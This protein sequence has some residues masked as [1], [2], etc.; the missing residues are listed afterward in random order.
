M[1]REGGSVTEDR[2]PSG[3]SRSRGDDMRFG[4][5]AN[6]RADEAPSLCG[7]RSPYDLIASAGFDTTDVSWDSPLAAATGAT[8]DGA[9][10][11][12]QARPVSSSGLERVCYHSD[13]LTPDIAAAENAAMQERRMRSACDLACS[14][15]LVHSLWVNWEPFDFSSARECKRYLDFD[16]STLL[17]VSSRCSARRL[18]LVIEN[19]PS[20]PLQYYVDLFGEIPPESAGMCLDVGHA[21][22]Q[23]PGYDTPLAAWIQALGDRIEHLHLHGNDGM[24]D[25]HLPVLAPGGTVDWKACFQALKAVSYRG[26]IHEELPPW[27]GAEL[28]GWA[29]L[30]RG[31]GPIRE[32]WA[33]C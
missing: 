3:E 12:P 14:L 17:E 32:L 28:I 22:L 20:F 6:I 26:V 24:K 31:S 16:T 23:A 25:I 4:C 2:R 11:S 7:D 15:F 33:S 9:V 1:Q 13:V 5:E 30:E 8:G 19:N 10:P 21:N 27:T 29:L 18:R